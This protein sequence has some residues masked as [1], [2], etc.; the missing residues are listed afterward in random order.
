MVVHRLVDRGLLDYDAPVAQYWP[1]FAQGG[2]ATMTVRDVLAHR[3]GL[4]DLGLVAATPVEALDHRLMERRLAAA[5][6]DRTRG[7]PMYHALTLGWLLAGLVRAVTGKG[8]DELYRTEVAE[9]LRLTG[10]YLGRP[11][12]GAPVDIAELVGTHLSFAGTRWGERAMTRACAVPGLGSAVRSLFIPGMHATLDGPAP[13]LMSAING[14]ATGF[15]TADALARV[16]AT[17][18]GDGSLDGRRLISAATARGL[19]RDRF[20]LPPW[21]LGYH[22]FPTVGALRAFGHIGINGVGGWVDP[23][24]ELA[25]GLMSNQFSAARLPF[26][27]SLMSAFLPTIMLAARGAGVRSSGTSRPLREAS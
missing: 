4:S 2:K 3:A 15:F 14:S 10:L 17:I 24:R 18:A 19:R 27:L 26:D 11:P 6:P 16:Y 9:P 25:V 13:A 1:E 5:T 21:H 23:E 12:A 8:M 20:V 7:I 22:T